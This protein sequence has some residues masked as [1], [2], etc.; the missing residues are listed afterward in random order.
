MNKPLR[1][2]DRIAICLNAGN[3]L[4]DGGRRMFLKNLAGLESRQISI[5]GNLRRMK[6]QIPS[7][8]LPLH[9]GPPVLL[10]RWKHRIHP[11]QR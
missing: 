9:T 8:T 5:E 4:N 3:H 1:C 7:L 10:V 2:L 11:G 6:K